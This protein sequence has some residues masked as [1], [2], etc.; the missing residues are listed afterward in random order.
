MGEF[1]GG[2][3]V[4]SLDKW[5]GG[6]RLLV[7]HAGRIETDE[8]H[9]S[10]DTARTKANALKQQL[11]EMGRKGVDAGGLEPV[12]TCDRGGAQNSRSGR[13]L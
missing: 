1:E 10:I 3:V 6:Y 12:K 8:S 5:K 2:E 7:E 11:V 13:T 9:P 4:C